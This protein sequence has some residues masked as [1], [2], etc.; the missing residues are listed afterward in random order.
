MKKI[1]VAVAM[2][3]YSSE[4]AISMKSGAVVCDA[5]DPNRYEI[6]P[7]HVTQQAWSYTSGDG[8][9]QEV[10]MGNFSFFNGHEAI[11]PDVVFNTIHGAPGEN[12]YIAALCDLAKIPQTSTHFYAAALTFNKRDCLSVLKSFGIRC[13]ESIY[14]NQGDAVSFEHIKTKLGLPFFI[15]PNRSGSSYGISRVASKDEF[16]TALD[17]AFLEDSEILIERALV[18]TEVSVGAYLYADQVH[19][20]TPTEIVSENDFFDFEAK[21]HGKSSEIT[22]AR[23][24]SEETSAVQMAAKRIFEALKM[25]GVSRTDFILEN[26]YPYFIETNSNPGLSQES[27]VPKQVR[28]AGM[29]LSTFFDQLIDDALSR[30]QRTK[31]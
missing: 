15:K 12:G 13:A 8:K 11:Q 24:T 7:I 5:L 20:L 26:G 3:G 27:L 22:P 23:I 19:V 17:K 28:Y 14:I 9:R 2:G 16:A 10:S 30:H 4:H 25:T 21:Y 1:K 29:T 18:G 31:L 6:Y